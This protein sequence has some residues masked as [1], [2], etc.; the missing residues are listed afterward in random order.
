MNKPASN[1]FIILSPSITSREASEL[2]QNI[3][4]KQG[5]T[6]LLVQ[7]LRGLPE[8]SKIS[9][10]LTQEVQDEA[11]NAE[12]QARRLGRGEFWTGCVTVESAVDMRK[13][14]FL[15]DS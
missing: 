2:L 9:H 5:A 6:M 11:G 8:C 15:S 7:G 3:E 4:A 14:S 10:C 1:P 13:P 12:G